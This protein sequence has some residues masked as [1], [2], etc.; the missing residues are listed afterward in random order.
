MKDRVTHP[1]MTEFD[2]EEALAEGVARSI[3]ETIRE[4]VKARGHASLALSGGS[5][6][7]KALRKLAMMTLPW[8]QVTITLV[9]DRWVAPSLPRSNQGMLMKVLLHD[10]PA[11]RFVPLFTGDAD[12]YAGAP[13]VEAALK[14]V[15]R[16]FDLVLL[17]MGTDG[18]TASLFPGGDTLKDAMD[19]TSGRRVAAM[20][21]PDALEARITLTLPA[22]LDTRHILLLFA[23]AEKRATYKKALEKGPVEEMPVRAILR[24]T[25]VPVD[26]YCA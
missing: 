22:I 20:T 25:E 7:Q 4:A 6:P 14:G 5:T 1:L 10:A 9:D 11:A 2:S 12:P 26:V 13:R 17:G 23:G 8:P 19:M 21:A 15:P 18:H 3:A 24:Q 16:P